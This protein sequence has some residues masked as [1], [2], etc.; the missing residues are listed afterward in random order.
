M[1]IFKLSSLLWCHSFENHQKWQNS[2]KKWRKTGPFVI[3]PMEGLVEVTTEVVELFDDDD[4]D[5][6]DCS[7]SWK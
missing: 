4:D 3:L 6:L 7:L 2:G 1:D 5:S